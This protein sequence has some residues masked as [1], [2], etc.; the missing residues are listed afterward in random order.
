MVSRRIRGVSITRSRSPATCEGSGWRL[1]F[2]RLAALVVIL[3]FCRA[4]C[5]E[6]QERPDAEVLR[7]VVSDSGR[8]IFDGL[9]A[10]LSADGSLGPQPEVA[11]ASPL[12]ALR[13]FCRGIRGTSP[14]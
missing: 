14:D 1:A 6:A 10:D 8:T 13:G 12:G 4:A 5:A 9:I 7:V 2:A 3:V 11:Y